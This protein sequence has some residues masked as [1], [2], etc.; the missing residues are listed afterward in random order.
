MG[1]CE[2][3]LLIN[4]DEQLE[5]VKEELNEFV[6]KFNAESEEFEL[7]IGNQPLSHFWSLLNTNFS[8]VDTNISWID[9]IKK[10]LVIFLVVLLVPALN[11][12][13]MISGRMEG[14]LSEMGLRKSFGASQSVLLR[15]VLTENL[16]LTLLG[17]TIGLILAWLA[18]IVER[19]FILSLIHI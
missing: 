18:L 4:S 14:R 10:F 16:L 13:G 8:N 12:S 9:F 17:G 11:L 7:T 1:P 2:I 5:S 6:R 15:Q 19:N 3:T